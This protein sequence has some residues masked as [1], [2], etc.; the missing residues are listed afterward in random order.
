LLAGCVADLG[1]RC[2]R[3][4]RSV[5]R[6]GGKQLELLGKRWLRIAGILP[7][8]F[9]HHVNHLNPAQDRPSGRHRLEPEHR[10]NAPLDGAMILFNAIVEVGT[11]PDLDR[12]QFAP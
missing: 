11:L 8:L 1:R 7:L 3:A 12:L 5:E 4:N 6:S 2:E 9:A 10:S